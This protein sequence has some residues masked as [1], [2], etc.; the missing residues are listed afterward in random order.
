[1]KVEIRQIL[2][3]KC[4]II[5]PRKVI[6][7]SYSHGSVLTSIF[8]CVFCAYQESSDQILNQCPR[9]QR[10]TCSKTVYMQVYT[11]RA[12][13]MCQLVWIIT[14]LFFQ[15]TLQKFHCASYY[16]PWCLVIVFKFNLSR[17]SLRSKVMAQ[18]ESI[19]D[20]LYCKTLYFGSPKC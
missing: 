17:L 18:N 1:M 3:H 15:A 14:C 8:Q 19:Y 20:F 9:A 11:W 16:L 13:G 4:L 10:Q 5:H 2:V 7:Q 12:L 6:W